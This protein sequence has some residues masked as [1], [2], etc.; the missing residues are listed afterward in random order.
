MPNANF[1]MPNFNI[2][3]ELAKETHEDKELS[4]QETKP[5]NCQSITNQNWVN[6]NL[7]NTLV[8]KTLM[9]LP[10]LNQSH[11]VLSLH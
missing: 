8:E 9:L 2:K 4:N 3:R 1:H 5:I 11:F 10:Y 6:P 7:L